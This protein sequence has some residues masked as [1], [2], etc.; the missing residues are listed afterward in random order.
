M[1]SI[2]TIEFRLDTS[3]EYG[4]KIDK[5]LKKIEEDSEGSP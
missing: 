5:L 1:K 4:S 2:P 3:I